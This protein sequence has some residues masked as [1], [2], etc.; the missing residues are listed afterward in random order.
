LLDD[1][2]RREHHLRA[3]RAEHKQLDEIAIQSHLRQSSRVA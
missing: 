2:H 3:Q 1:Q